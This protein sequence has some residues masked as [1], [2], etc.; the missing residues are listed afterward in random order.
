MRQGPAVL[1]AHPAAAQPAQVALYLHPGEAEVL[2][3]S[4]AEL[5]AQAAEAA[6]GS[7][8]AAN[9]TVWLGC[10]IANHSLMA[11]TVVEVVDGVEDAEECCRLC[12]EMD[13]GAC[14]A[15][16]W[17]QQAGGCRCG[18]G[19]TGAGRQGPVCV[20]WPVGAQPNAMPLSRIVAFSCHPAMLMPSLWPPLLQL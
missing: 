4:D 15:W 19:G 10:I 5:L 2:V 16:N 1:P 17:C 8:A 14:N 9:T 12:R 18:L 7:G 20:C 3:P 11:G 6:V 13:G